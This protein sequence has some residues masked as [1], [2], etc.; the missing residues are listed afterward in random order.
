ML[1]LALGILFNKWSRLVHVYWSVY[2]TPVTWPKW[3]LHLL[4][5]VSASNHSW[6]LRFQREE[7]LH[8]SLPLRTTHVKI[9]LYVRR[10]MFTFSVG[11][12]KFSTW[13]KY[14]PWLHLIYWFHLTECMRSG[15]L[16]YRF[17]RMQR[18]FFFSGKKEKNKQN[19]HLHLPIFI[20]YCTLKLSINKKLK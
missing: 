16:I 8:S 9:T 2:Y 18:P 15:W 12:C 6:K 10:V 11:R 17:K 4:T 14:L 5:Q 13:T 1:D 7:N 20:V 19:L 3:W